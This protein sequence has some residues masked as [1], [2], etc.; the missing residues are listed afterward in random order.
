M[1][2]LSWHEKGIILAKEKGYYCDEQGN[3]Y[4]K[5]GRQLRPYKSGHYLRFGIRADKLFDKRKNIQVSVHKFI[6]YCKFG[7]I[8]FMD[9]V[10]VRHKNGNALDNRPDNI[11]VGTPRDN[12]LDIPEATRLALASHAASFLRKYTNAQEKAIR[13]HYVASKSYRLTMDKFGVKKSTLHYILHKKLTG[14]V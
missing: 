6:A 13:E 1:T 5:N 8:A 14:V 4:N 11:F 9:G 7:E 12:K 10:Y 3:I 2:Q